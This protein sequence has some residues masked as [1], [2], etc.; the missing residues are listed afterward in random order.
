[1]KL[2]L[3]QIPAEGLH[4]E[5]AIPSVQLE[6][7]PEGMRPVGPLHCSLDLGLSGGGLFATGSF[8]LEMEFDC[9]GCLTPF[10]RTI[11][12]DD[13]AVQMELAGPETVDLTPYLREDTLLALPSHP[14]CDWEGNSACPGPG[15]GA[16]GEPPG[17]TAS[18]AWGV[19]DQLNPKQ[20]E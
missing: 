16:P 20:K 8:E 13:F 12:V 7:P 3:Q 19:L 17:S 18:P 5:E 6:L 15:S 9:V 4:V 14:R 11:R 2:H 10:R 1:M